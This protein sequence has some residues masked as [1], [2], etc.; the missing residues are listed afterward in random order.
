MLHHPIAR[1]VRKVSQ[2]PE[3]LPT[4]VGDYAAGAKEFEQREINGRSL[5]ACSMISIWQ[6]N[7][8]HQL[9][10]EF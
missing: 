1:S 3:S 6:K 4:P 2:R 8:E 9:K 7:K 10:L 5:R